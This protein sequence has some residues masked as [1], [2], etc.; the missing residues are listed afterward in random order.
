[1]NYNLKL[2]KGGSKSNPSLIDL[3]YANKTPCENI[4]NSKK[5]YFIGYITPNGKVILAWNNTNV[6][7]DLIDYYILL[8]TFDALNELISEQKTLIDKTQQSEKTKQL[9]KITIEYLEKSIDKWKNEQNEIFIKSNELLVKMKDNKSEFSPYLLGK[10]YAYIID[11]NFNSDAERSITLNLENEHKYQFNKWKKTK[12]KCNINITNYENDRDPELGDWK[13][14]LYE[15]VKS[16][17]SRAS[18]TLL[19]RSITQS[20]TAEGIKSLTQKIKKRNKKHSYK[21]KPN[22]RKRTHNKRDSTS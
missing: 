15:A 9:K 19:T 18:K 17:L 4:G 12:D 3:G 11:I 10:S 5:R 16:S 1:M 21:Q 14:I 8:D 20:N 13:H 22:Q 2:L 6:W 7:K